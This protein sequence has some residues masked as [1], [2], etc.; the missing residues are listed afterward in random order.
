M[1]ASAT[2]DKKTSGAPAAP[3][4]PLWRSAVL[5]GVVAAAIILT[6]LSPDANSPTQAGVIMRLPSI[7]GM[8]VGLDQEMSPAEKAILPPDT[9]LIRKIYSSINGDQIQT[10]IV[11]AGGEKRSIHR[12][13]VCLPGQGWIIK[14]SEVV[15]I[16]LSDKK[17]LQA[18]LLTLE[19]EVPTAPGKSIM[20]QS[21]FLY[22]FVGKDVS[23]PYHMRR[24][25]LTSW[26]RV[27]HN[28]NHRWA[29]ISMN[30]LITSNLK[31]GGKDRAE[32]LSM[33]EGF[34]A[35]LTPKIMPSGA[36]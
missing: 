33:L 3:G 16:K 13:E 22:W 29:F 11:L 23:T 32:T 36:P 4:I 30:A 17:E 34:A 24:V 28:I 31:Q 8:F 35:Q 20:V 12:P 9:E 5:A 26:D 10:S 18:M 15:P 27:V 14:S 7:A 21:L 1:S 2:P 19:R 25:W 6:L